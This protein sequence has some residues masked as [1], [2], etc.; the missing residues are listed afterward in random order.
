MALLVPGETVFAG[1]GLLSIV[2]GLPLARRRVPPNRWYRVRLSATMADEYVWY[3]ANA[4]CGRDL[5]VLGVVVAAVALP[6]P[7]LVTLSA[8]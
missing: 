3:A 6:L 5:M 1:I 2:I 4:T 7:Q 8:A